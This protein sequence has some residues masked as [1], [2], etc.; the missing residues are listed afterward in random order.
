[1]TNTNTNA[2]GIRGR[3]AAAAWRDVG[4]L[5]RNLATMRRTRAAAVRDRR[6]WAVTLIDGAID[7]V[8]AALTATGAT[9][10]R[11]AIDGVDVEQFRHEA[12]RIDAG[13]L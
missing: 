3:E 6:Y 9:L 10:A 12:G 7:A 8:R 11:L 5:S 1:M 13:A 4:L 2:Y